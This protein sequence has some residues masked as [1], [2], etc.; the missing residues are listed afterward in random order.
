ME[1]DVSVWTILILFISGSG[2]TMISV[3]LGGYLM[4]RARSSQPSEKFL[5]GQA[6]GE[7]FTVPDIDNLAEFPGSGEPSK[8]EK[9]VLKKTESFLKSLSGGK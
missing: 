4:F 6:K 1:F 7:V 2:I 9:H 8:E 3:L 5:G